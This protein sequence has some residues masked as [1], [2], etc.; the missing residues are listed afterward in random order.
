MTKM[1]SLLLGTAAGLVAVA[2]A[3]AAD[4]PVKAKPVQYVKICTLYGD[5]YYYVPGSDICI[6]IGGYVRADYGWNNTGARTVNYKGASGA[7]D[8]TVSD[9][10]TRHRGNLQI[11]TRAQTQ[12]GTLRTFTSIHVNNENQ[13]SQSVDLARAFIQFAGF[14]I[15]HSKSYTDTFSLGDNY[16][17]QQLQNEYSTGA[18]GINQIS[19][20]FEFGN[21]VTL[22]AGADEPSRKSLYGFGASY[23]A[24]TGT[25]AAELTDSHKGMEWM[26]PYLAFKIEQAW[27][28]FGVTGLLH[29]ANVT[30]YGSSTL[31]DTTT[32]HPGDT[33]GWHVGAGGEIKLPMIAKGDRIGG[34]FNYGVGAT[35]YELKNTG[36]ADL[37]GAGNNVALGFITDGVF[38]GTNAANGTSIEL[39]TAWSAGGGFEHYWTPLLRSSVYGQYGRITYDATA[40]AYFAQSFGCGGTFGSA[41]ASNTKNLQLNAATNTCNPDWSL[42][43]VGTRSIWQPVPGLNLGLDLYYTR[44]QT[45]FAGLATFASIPSGARP[46]G[47]YSVNDQGIFAA[48]F[49][50]QRNFNAGD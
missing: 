46:A 24:K 36:S 12:Y 43:T 33:F 25:V 35:A 28:Y 38:A 37:F 21:G 32:G 13:G 50:A 45:A 40:K 15:G 4:M 39:T 2:G 1:K 9:L 31:M 3:Q 17:L 10:S 6:K 27:G 29:D 22:S 20:T 41:V 8:R 16:A 26:D 7:Q 49:R 14:T 19:Y 11:D 34:V 18:N 47:T 44:V 23:V 30:Y 48:V 5:G 42:W